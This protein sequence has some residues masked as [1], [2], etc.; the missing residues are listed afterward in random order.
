MSS[1]REAAFPTRMTLQIYKARGVGAS[2]G[3]ELLKKK[4][5]ALSARLRALLQPI[6]ATKAAV[7][8]EMTG[9]AFAI[10]EAVWAAGDFRKKVR[11]S[12]GGG[13]LGIGPNEGAILLRPRRRLLRSFSRAPCRSSRH[14]RASEPPFV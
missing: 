3:L 13:V 8:T 4:S 10:S 9:A 2:K 5:D 12:R 6:K 1:N 7:G 14:H 11:H